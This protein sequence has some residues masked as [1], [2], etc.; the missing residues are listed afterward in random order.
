MSRGFR[1][2]WVRCYC[3]WVGV[4]G[5]GCEIVDHGWAW[6]GICFVDPCIQLQIGVKLLGC[7]EYANQEAL[8]A[9]ASDSEW[10]FIC[11]IQPYAIYGWAWDGYGLGM[12]TKSK[13]MLGS[14]RQQGLCIN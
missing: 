2:A 14:D 13:K 7:K 6:I 11:L 3:P 8:R 12:G 5:H 1:W 10:P 4:G 9:K